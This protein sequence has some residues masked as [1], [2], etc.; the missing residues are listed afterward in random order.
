VGAQLVT[1]RQAG[2]GSWLAVHGGGG[3]ERRPA[4]RGT[5]RFGFGG[6]SRFVQRSFQAVMT[7]SVLERRL[8]EALTW[9]LPRS[10]RRR[11]WEVAIDWHL[12]SYYGQPHRSR[13]ELYYGQPK[14]GP[15]NST[16]TLRPA[17][18]VM[19]IAIPW[20]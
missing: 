9:D 8:N 12:S 18:S 11:A 15:R 5:V 16:P 19:D 4:R 17:S 14:Q 13:N 2:K 6:L 7:A 10:L 20:P 1:S 3:A